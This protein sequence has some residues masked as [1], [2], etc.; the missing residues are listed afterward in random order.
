MCRHALSS[1]AQ[2]QILGNELRIIL[3]RTRVL[4]TE[5]NICSFNPTEVFIE[6]LSHCLSQ[7]HGLFSIIKLRCLYLWENYRGTLDNCD[8]HEGLPSKS[9]QVYGSYTT[10]YKRK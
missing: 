3:Y 2:S 4:F 10:D 7:K 6:I 9:F 8:K 1:W 5:L